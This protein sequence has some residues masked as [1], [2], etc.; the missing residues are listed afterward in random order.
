M[1]RPPH[2]DSLLASEENIIFIPSLALRKVAMSSTI[3]RRFFF[4]SLNRKYLFRLV[5]VALAGY[6]LFGYLLIPLRIQGHSMD[7]TY[8]DDSFAFCWRPHYFFSPIQRFDVVTVRFTGRSV[9]LL[10]RVI[11]LPGETV[12][13]REGKLYVNGKRIAEPHVQHHST[14]DLPPRTIAPDHVYV[15]GDNRGTTMSRHHFGQVRM[16]RIVGGVIL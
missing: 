6:L 16:E 3:I 15:I 11:A 5:V 7:P 9:M 14:W 1:Q 8:P 10:K 4:P 12:E 2:P 13:F